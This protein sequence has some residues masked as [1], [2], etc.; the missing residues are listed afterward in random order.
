[1]IGGADLGESVQIRVATQHHPG[2]QAD[3][4]QQTAQLYQSGHH[5]GTEGLLDPADIERG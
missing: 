2:A 1:M 3:D 4:Q 5:I